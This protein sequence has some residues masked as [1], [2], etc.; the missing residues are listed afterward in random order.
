MGPTLVV[1]NDDTTTTPPKP[2][3]FEGLTYRIIY[4]SFD[5]ETSDEIFVEVEKKGWPSMFGPFLA[6]SSDRGGFVL[7]TFCV[8]CEDILLMEEVAAE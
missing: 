4:S 2:P 3:L 8:P 5:V 6:I 7:P 1:N